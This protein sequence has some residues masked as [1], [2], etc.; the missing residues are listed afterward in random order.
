MIW[1]ETEEMTPLERYEKAKRLRDTGLT[2][3]AIGAELG[4]SSTRVRQ[5]LE[6]LERRAWR[7]EHP[8]PEPDPPLPDPWWHGLSAR[9]LNELQCASFDSRESCA[10][11]A[12]D[13]LTV[14]HGVV[15]FRDTLSGD[16]WRV[17]LSV[18]NEVRA[19][20]GCQ[21]LTKTRKVT[22][23][24]ALDRARKLLERNGWKVEPPVEHEE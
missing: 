13:N 14:S 7:A 12:S 20:L 15:V 2:L 8:Q 22:S 10:V 24:A 1:R 21:P 6:E 16:L 17:P 19:W 9:T 23:A 3:K 4:V 11:F 18:V 5:M